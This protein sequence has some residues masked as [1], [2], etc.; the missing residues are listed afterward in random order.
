MS[1]DRLYEEIPAYGLVLLGLASHTLTLGP[2]VSVTPDFVGGADI[3]AALFVSPRR[4]D[5]IIT[6]GVD[7]VWRVVS[8]DSRTLS[9]SFE[10]FLLIARTGR[11]FT[12]AHSRATSSAGSTGCP[13]I[14]PDFLTTVVRVYSYGRRLPGLQFVASACA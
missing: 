7:R 6:I 14:W 4:P 10:P 1:T 5:Y 12:A 3:S 11:I 13:S 9:W 8:E 2:F